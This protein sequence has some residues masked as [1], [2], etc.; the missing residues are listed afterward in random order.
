MTRFFLSLPLSLSLLWLAALPVFAQEAAVTNRATE[1]RAE[2]RPDAPAVA[3]L[4]DGAKVKVT[5][6]QSGWTRVES[7]QGAGWVRVFHLRFEAVA[8]QSTES[9]GGSFLSF[10]RGPQK[11]QSRQTATIGI[12][13]LS[14]EELKDANPDPEALKRLQAWRADKAAGDRFA[15]EGKLTAVSVDYADSGKGSR[16]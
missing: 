1:L 9:S 11:T 3:A 13:G 4:P 6:R 5:T 10:L 12:R 16:K 7:A 8:T 15:R 14:E 2:P